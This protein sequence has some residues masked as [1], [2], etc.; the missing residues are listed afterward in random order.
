MLTLRLW[1]RSTERDSI[2]SLLRLSRLRD[3]GGR[4]AVFSYQLTRLDMELETFQYFVEGRLHGE[5]Q[6]QYV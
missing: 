6:H 1:V 5:T 3:M 4:L 2:L